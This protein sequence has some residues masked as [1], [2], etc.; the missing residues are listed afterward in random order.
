MRKV[1]VFNHISLDGY[2]VDAKGDMSFAQNT[3]PDTE[4][5]AY[6]SGNAAGGG[7]LVFGRITYEMMAGFWPTPAAAAAMPAVAETMNNSPKVVFSKTLDKVDWKNTKLV[8]ADPVGEIRRMKKEPGN[9]MIIFGSG[10]IVSQL[11]QNGLINEYV[12]IV[13]PVVLGKGRTMFAGIKEN[14]RLNLV[15]TRAFKNGNVLL[16]YMPA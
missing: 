15:D 13:D 14:L 7:T 5:D 10:T 16:R 12:I 8:K 1:M 6:V 3:K 2:F 9:D 4:W 11:A